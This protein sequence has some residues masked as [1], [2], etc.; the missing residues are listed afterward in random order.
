MSKH[1]LNGRVVAITGGA[2]G[3]G[4]ATARA[5][6]AAGMRVAIGDREGAF[7]A[8]TAASL[9][10]NAI[11]L[12]VDVRDA[13]S[14][15]SFI[16]QTE[17]RLGPLD[18]LINNAGVF[19]GGM[20]GEEAP[21]DIDRLVGVNVSGV[22]HGSRLALE[23]FRPRGK[24]HIVNVASSAGLVPLPGGAAYAATKWAVVG[25]T[26]SLRGEL[27]G[28]GVRTTLVCPGHINTQMSSGFSKLPGLRVL[29]P[30]E[31]ADAIVAALRSGQAEVIVPA[32]LGLLARIR[33][34]LPQT[35]GDALFRAA[36]S[37]K[38]V[39][40]GDRAAQAEYA[41]K[42]AAQD[43]TAPPTARPTAEARR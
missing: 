20:F 15:A 4:L 43:A 14:F 38:L 2:R 9:D 21:G 6:V 28:S 7:T 34:L 29:E 27:H 16:A 37:N 5:C 1:D 3:I 32:E 23:R 33:A 24:G 10:P 18:V 30:H 40:G 22:F 31:V 12:A 41:R 39:L 26:R 35:T 17:R 42:A 19:Q 36:G 25:F 11:G 8:E 13:D